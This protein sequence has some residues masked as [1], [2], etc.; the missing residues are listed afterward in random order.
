[1]STS[2]SS[3]SAEEPGLL[4]RGFFPRREPVQTEPVISEPEAR[5]AELLQRA[6]DDR[7]DEGIRAIEEQATG[8]MREV[9]GE[10]WRSS[11]KDVRPEQERI[12][13][14]L[15]RDQA[16][17]SLIASSDERFQA[18]AVRS[19]SLED[20]LQE[21]TDSERRT[22]AAMEATA[23]A[24]R[25][26]A[27][28]PTLHGVEAVRTQLEMVERHI[29]EAFAHF[30][31]R[32]EAIATEV[33]G[34]VR[35]HGELMTRETT[36]I[37]ESM[38]A[39]V[40]GGTETV[41]RLAQRIEEHAKLFVLQDH[42][43]VQHVREVVEEQ[44]SE[45]TEQVAMVREKVGLHGREQEQLRASLERAIDFRMRGLAELI[46]SDSTALRGLIED[47]AGAVIA[48]GDGA[49]D[50]GPL[51]RVVDDRMAALEHVVEERMAALER[52]MGE[53]VLALSSAT[54]A[55]LERNVE[56]MA[57]AAG[58]V[59]GPDELTAE[60]QRSFEERMMNHIDERAGAIA[61]LIRS[62]SQA[63]ADRVA[64]LAPAGGTSEPAMDGELV[65]Q[66]IRSIKEL[67]AGMASDMAGSV[68]RRFQTL[69]DQLHKETQLQAEAM[70]KIAEV[71]GE[72]IDR[73][74]IRVDEGVGNDIQIVVD[75]MSDAIRAMS[76]VRR[77]SA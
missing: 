43:I 33:L 13:S 71:L 26:I 57:V 51:V 18:I 28:S 34:R 38:Q 60:T 32:D 24:I 61:R 62:D 8:L 48:S 74:S 55:S 56:R 77:E 4:R 31:Q 19:A 37:V 14:I 54:S 58:S 35:D 21:L 45:L 11:A 65:R 12:V 76:T 72:K 69:S 63:L 29:A 22:R 75:R 46:R 3:P 6:V 52:T 1:M 70:L 39:Y 40:Q 27:D 7:L 25:E 59:D 68:D 47:R 30:D 73:L 16:I 9:A 50:A 53:Q 44:A 36:R 17:R 66:L 10:V 15:S 41:G 42:N 49:L 23:H 64:S 2:G 67:E 5:L 20:H